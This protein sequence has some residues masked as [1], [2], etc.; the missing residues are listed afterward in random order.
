MVSYIPFIY[1]STFLSMSSHSTTTWETG[2]VEIGHWANGDHSLD[3]NWTPMPPWKTPMTLLDWTKSDTNL[4]RSSL[5][6]CYCNS[7]SNI[8]EE[9]M[10]SSTW[11]ED[12]P[13]KPLRLELCRD[14][15]C[16]MRMTQKFHHLNVTC[17][18]WMMSYK[19][20]HLNSPRTQQCWCVYNANSSS[21]NPG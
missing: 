6:P 8:W 16:W 12:S 21:N 2:L 4:W 20:S 9:D 18:P 7:W 5:N 13:T 14:H 1:S 10:Y 15:I 11:N 19:G 3:T 17:D